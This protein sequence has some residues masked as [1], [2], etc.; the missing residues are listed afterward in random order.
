MCVFTLNIF[1]QLGFD[2]SRVRQFDDANGHFVQR[3]KLGGAEPSR[4]GNYLVLVIFDRADKQGL[5]DAVRLK[6]GRQ[7]RQTV[8]IKASAWVAGGFLQLRHRQVAIFVAVLNC[9]FHK[10]LLLI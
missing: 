9:G 2:A 5:Q 1:N 3:G 10:K 6:T 8:L 4:S 7:F